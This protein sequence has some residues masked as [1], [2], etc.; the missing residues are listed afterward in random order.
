MS[1]EALGIH[2]FNLKTMV[3]SS[4]VQYCTLVQFL[5]LNISVVRGGRRESPK[6]FRI[7]RGSTSLKLCSANE[8]TES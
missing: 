1:D 5:D 7:M 6:E 8:E 4:L 2:N 3:D